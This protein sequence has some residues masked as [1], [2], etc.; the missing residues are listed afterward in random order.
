MKFPNEGKAYRSARAKLLR[1]EIELRRRIEKV[2]KARRKLPLGGE[3]PEDYE[4]E[5]EQG[6]VRMSRLFG[7]G[8]TLVAYSFMYGPNM[9][10]PCPMCSSM[11]DALNGNA[12]HVM[13]R[14]NLVVIAKSSLSRILEFARARGWNN[15]RL[16]SSA[17]N[18]YNRDY[19]GEDVG[20]AQWPMM[21]VFVRRKGKI[22]HSWASEMMGAKA[23]PGQNDR[24]I[25]LMWPLWNVLDLTPE[26]RGNWY[27]PLSAR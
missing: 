26:G 14:T 20:G 8:D 4:F 12:R 18:T 1:E 11:L 7:N 2:A 23:D 15:L 21:N 6:K 27:P 17:G 13:Q 24:H 10:A 3:V 22:R 19:R 5:S 9:A 25:D 16:L